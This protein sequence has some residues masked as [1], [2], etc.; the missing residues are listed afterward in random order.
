MKTIIGLVGAKASGKTTTFEF[1]QEIYP[2]VV[3]IT[4]AGKLKDTC[5]EV[6]EIPREY[7]DKQNLKEA[8]LDSPVYLTVENIK[9]VHD[10]YRLHPDYDAFIRLHIG[11]ILYTP[12]EVAQYI[13]T[14]VLRAYQDDIHCQWSVIG[15]MGK[16]GDIGVVTDIRFPNELSFFKD[17]YPNFHPIYIK[18]TGAEAEAAK[19]TH[20]SEA[21]LPQLKAASREISNDADKNTL[22][23]NISVILSEILGG[24]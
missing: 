3:E 16:I 11:R 23:N 4:L 18:N 24:K 2:N 12:R 22:R 19:D 21:H 5:S 8:D 10:K 6:F 14:E 7:F 9:A 13:G 17:N 15:K 20:A 1:I